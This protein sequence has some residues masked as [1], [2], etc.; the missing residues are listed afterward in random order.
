MLSLSSANCVNKLLRIP[1]PMEIHHQ[2]DTMERALVFFF[3]FNITVCYHIFCFWITIIFTWYHWAQMPVSYPSDNAASH[4]H[5]TYIYISIV[6]SST[7]WHPSCAYN[8]VKQYGIQWHT[9]LESPWCKQN[10]SVHSQWIPRNIVIK[11]CRD[12][13]RDIISWVFPL[14]QIA[15]IKSRDKVQ[16]TKKKILGLNKSVRSTKVKLRQ[17]LKY[18]DNKWYEF[19]SSLAIVWPFKI[20][21]KICDS[22]GCIFICHNTN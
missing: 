18:V 17:P 16:S 20:C 2:Y 1:E 12:Y 14:M 11:W 8:V 3:G 9:T 13:S 15:E 21:E 7:H 5:V 19:S 4:I 10:I 22:F 6:F